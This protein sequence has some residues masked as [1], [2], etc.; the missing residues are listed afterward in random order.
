MRS[1]RIMCAL[2]TLIAIN[3]VAITGYC[4][5]TLSAR[6]D[7]WTGTESCLQKPFQGDKIRLKTKRAWSQL[8]TVLTHFGNM[9][10]FAP[11][12]IIDVGANRG[13]WS[14]EVLQ[15]FPRAN[16]L[17]CEPNSEHKGSLVSLQ[18]QFEQARILLSEKLLGNKKGLV[19]Y[20]ANSKA[21]TGNSIYRENTKHFGPNNTD[22]SVRLMSM[23][24]LQDL[25][26]DKLGR[27]ACIDF[28]K[29]DA[30]GA[31]LDILRGGKN[32][33]PSISILL[34][35]MSLVNY[36]VHGAK[37][38][39]IFKYLDKNGFSLVHIVDLQ[40]KRGVMIAVDALFVNKKS[41]LIGK[42]NELIY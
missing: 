2:S 8:T 6:T 15:I 9:Y 42:I 11:I 39:D 25:V 22:V 16:Y 31:E 32:L 21:N 4:L 33:L 13:D 38:A 27:E 26:K 37:F 18:V 12:N 36:N 10:D 41:P 7:S 3:F 1:Q 30:Q 34:L 19:P 5:W 35:E 24:T 40:R 28:L 20:F 14:R 29:I 17:L 23:T